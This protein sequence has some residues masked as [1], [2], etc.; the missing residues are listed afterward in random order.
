MTDA[1]LLGSL[2]SGHTRL[3]MRPE[4]EICRPFCL[5]QLSSPASKT[6][7]SSPTII[8]KRCTWNYSQAKRA[9]P[10]GEQC[11][12]SIGAFVSDTLGRSLCRQLASLRV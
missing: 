3:S 1:I 9:R 4:A 12:F 6:H 10:C 5:A 11:L 8:G 2:V 7:S